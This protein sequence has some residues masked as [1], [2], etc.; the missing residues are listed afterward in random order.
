MKLKKFRLCRA[1]ALIAVGVFLGRGAHADTTVTFDSAP[2]HNNRDLLSDCVPPQ[3]QN[4]NQPPG[5]T[6]FGNYAAA[7]TPGVDVSGIGT[8]NIGITWYSDNYPDTRWEYYNKDFAPWGNVAGGSGVVQLQGSF[9]GTAH[10]L[11]FTPNSS[12]AAVDIESFSFF[13][14]YD[15]VTDANVYGG[16]E[17]YTFNI[18]VLSGKLSEV[19]VRPMFG[20]P[21]PETAIPGLEATTKFP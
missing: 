8:P 9:V 11:V 15:A 21:N 17:R 7:S 2:S 20:V 19:Q 14:Y 12:S 10:E 1:G 5:I 13:P 3:V 6:N 18:S 4:S 16:L